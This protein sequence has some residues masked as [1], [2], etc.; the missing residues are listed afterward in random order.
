[1]YSFLS[2]YRKFVKNTDKI[3]CGKNSDILFKKY[4]C[5]S[6]MTDFYKMFLKHCEGG[7]RLRAYFIKLGYELGGK[8]SDERIYLPCCAIEIMQTGILAQDDV[9]D[10]SPL[11]RGKP[12]VHMEFG[13]G[14]TGESCAVCFGDFGIIAGNDM[15]LSSDFPSDVCAF[16]AKI[17]NRI[18]TQTIAGQLYD[19]KLSSGSEDYLEED[20]INLYKFKTARYTSTG[21]LLLGSAFA[22]EYDK[23]YPDILNAGDNIGIAFQIKDDIIGIFSDESSSGKTTLSDMREGKKTILTAHF[24]RNA[25]ERDKNAF[26]EIYGK[27]T[28]GKDELAK[29]QELLR[30]CGSLCY[31]EKLCAEYSEKARSCINTSVFCENSKQKLN[32]ILN[33]LIERK[34]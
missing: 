6:L 32:E 28:S 15:I 33:F 18:S 1:M 16:A 26:F 34:K 21:P 29:V 4:D 14:H 31:A 3:L 19:I 22:Q 12:A 2:D 13:G 10:N 23:M 11:R 17:L 9:M 27:E 30:N 5:D 8:I 20:I 24:I 25:S 7:K